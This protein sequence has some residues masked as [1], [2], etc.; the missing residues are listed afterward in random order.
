MKTYRFYSKYLNQDIIKYIFSKNPNWKEADNNENYID[1]IYIDNYPKYKNLIINKKGYIKTYFDEYNSEMKKLT[2][3]SLLYENMYKY[4]KDFTNKYF[5]PQYNLSNIDINS[6]KNIFDNNTIWILKPT[7]LT[8]DF[9]F[10]GKGIKILKNFNEIKYIKNE[11][12][13]NISSYKKK[14]KYKFAEDETWVIA[15]YINN[16]LLFNNKKFHLRIY[17]IL[18]FNNNKINGYVFNLYPIFTAKK[19]YKNENYENKD[20]H[21]THMQKGKEN[22]LFFPSDFIIQKGFDKTQKIL[23]DIKIICQKL[24]DFIKTNVNI[25]CYED[26]KFCYELY[27]LDLMITEDYNVKILELNDK[28]GISS[29]TEIPIFS[30][31]FLEVLIEST[32][33]N[34][35]EDKYKFNIFKN[36]MFKLL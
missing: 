2:N 28:P 26:S 21:D 15:K 34:I 27:G 10:K 3:K 11:E 8:P 1:F 5:M 36:L 22:V 29:L 4:D 20:I 14:H 17:F 16:P 23:L 6:L 32:I 33:N 7:F 35:Y 9:G 31:L 24:F 18:T 13:K 19:N 25:K 12:L 30:L